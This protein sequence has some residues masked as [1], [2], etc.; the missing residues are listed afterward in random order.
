MNNSKK[1]KQFCDLRLLDEFGRSSERL[2][3]S[4]VFNLLSLSM[5]LMAEK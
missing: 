2:T 3:P 1:I 5:V 4:T